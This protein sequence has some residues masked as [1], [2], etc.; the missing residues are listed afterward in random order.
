MEIQNQGKKS[1]LESLSKYYRYKLYPALKHRRG[2]TKLRRVLEDLALRDID[3]ISE[4]P[5]TVFSY[6]WDNLIIIDACRHD[7]YEELNG[8]T[9]YR[10]SVGSCTG[11]YVEK[12][13]SEGDFSEVVYVSANG[14]LSDS[15][16]ASLTGNPNPFHTKYDLFRDEWDEDAGA[17]LPGPVV[18]A[19]RSAEKLFPE[20]QKIIHFLQPHTPFLNY[21]IGEKKSI[22]NPDDSSQPETAWDLANRGADPDVVRQAYRENLELV[23]EHVEELVDDL[24]GKT[25][26][27]SDHGNLVGENSFFGHPCGKSLKPLRKVPWDVRKNG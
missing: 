5:K 21:D 11:D 9:D 15:K 18:D 7:I 19:A 13:F 3:E 4:E 6:E 17:V 8:D 10:F 20:K 22:A 12:T 23:M 16:M 26:V 27:T 14:F 2:A 25:V 24:E 1:F